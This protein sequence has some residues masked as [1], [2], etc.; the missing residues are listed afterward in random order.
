[1][2]FSDKRIRSSNMAIYKAILK[3]GLENFKLE[4]LE[5]CNSDILLCFLFHLVAARRSGPAV[6]T[7]PFVVR[8]LRLLGRYLSEL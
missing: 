1:M 5:Y 7:V 6:I 4:I 8:I 3:Y 2:Y